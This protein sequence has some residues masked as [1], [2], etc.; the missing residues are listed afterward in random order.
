MSRK[1]EGTIHQ[2][3]TFDDI[4][5]TIIHLYII[6]YYYI[7]NLDWFSLLLVLV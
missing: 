6:R 4:V 7:I 1:N 5:N 3:I 2:N